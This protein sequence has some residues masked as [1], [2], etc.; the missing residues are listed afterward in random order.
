MSGLLFLAL[1]FFAVAQASTVRNGGQSAADAAALAAAR[2]DRDQFFDGFLDSLGDEDSWQDWLD[3]VAPI[4]GDGCGAAGDFAGKNDSDVLDC[5]PVTREQDPG[6]TVRIETRFTTGKTIVPGTED[7]TAKAS[8]TAVIRPLCDFG[9]EAG[10]TIEITCDG[11]DIEIDP[12]DDDLD[13]EPS[14]LF[15]VVLVD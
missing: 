3:L 12:E 9:D 5:E 6:Y 15:S 2:D 14:D 10:K 7:K 4:T 11:E 13:L 1:A 8:A